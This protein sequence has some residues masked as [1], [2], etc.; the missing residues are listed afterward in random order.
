[1]HTTHITRAL[2]GSL[3]A[4]AV[5]TPVAFA[6]TSAAKPTPK[7]MPMQAV[8]TTT[9]ASARLIVTYRTSAVAATDY[10][11][12][13]AI[14]D[15][16]A[17]RASLRMPATARTAAA[18]MRAS[19]LRALKGGSDLMAVGRMLNQAELDKIVA[20]LKADPAVQAVAVDRMMRPTV[21]GDFNDPYIADQ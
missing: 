1:M 4:L 19:R 11:R 9:R 20:Q 17:A 14:V 5:L 3:L 21:W 18:P 12:K 8:G 2:T 13:R 7:V 6:A 15:A 16:A 10:T